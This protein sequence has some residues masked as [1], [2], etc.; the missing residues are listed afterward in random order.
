[1]HAILV[2]VTQQTDGRDRDLLALF[3]RYPT[4]DA[5][6]REAWEGRFVA[7]WD[8]NDMLALLDTWQRGD[9]SVVRHGGNF[10]DSLKAISAKGLI[11]P[12]K[13]DLY[14]CVSVSRALL[15]VCHRKLTF[16]LPLTARLGTSGTSSPRP[17]AIASRSDYV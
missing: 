11:M 3:N 10:G 15:S 13:T 2:V 5:F 12:S 4:L 16:L 14:F 7:N 1:M 6:I 17:C 9:I 8:A